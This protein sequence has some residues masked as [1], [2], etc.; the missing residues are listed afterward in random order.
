MGGHSF[1]RQHPIGPYILDFY[2]PSAKLAVELDGDQHASARGRAHDAV[3]SQFL[4]KQ[5]ICVLRFANHE[6]N[7]NLDGVLDG[8]YR[9]LSSGREA[10]Q[11]E[12]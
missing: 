5:G 3:R 10:I 7:E 9:A 8:I 4:T 2:C 6:L 12:V 1:R 11:T